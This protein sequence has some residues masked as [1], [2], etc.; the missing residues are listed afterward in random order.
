MF[1]CSHRSGIYMMG[2]YFPGNMLGDREL[3][4]V[5]VIVTGWQ[6][7]SL[8]LYRLKQLWMGQLVHCSDY[9]GPHW[10]C[11]PLL[12]PDQEDTKLSRVLN[13][14][15][16]L[17]C[18]CRSHWDTF[19]SFLEHMELERFR[20]SFLAGGRFTFLSF[21][22]KSKNS[23]YFL[24]PDNFGETYIIQGLVTHFFPVSC[25]FPNLDLETSI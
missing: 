9:R 2:A 25:L 8:K 13:V 5:I 10:L 11:Q 22:G 4:E 7:L 18:S 17:T 1:P 12:K 20:E 6:P 15:V 24:I 21:P 19:Y 23:R 3:L 16:A 14:S